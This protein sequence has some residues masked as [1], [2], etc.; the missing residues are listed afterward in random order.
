MDEKK[1]TSKYHD[2]R[3]IKYG[4]KNRKCKNKKRMYGIK[5]Y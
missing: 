3:I 5:K 2:N 1:S 4:K